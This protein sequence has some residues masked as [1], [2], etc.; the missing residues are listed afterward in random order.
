MSKD[1]HDQLLEKM[2]QYFDLNLHWEGRRT[3]V[4]GIE[5]R[6]LLSDIRRL[7]SQRRVEIQAVRDQKPRLKSP[8]YRE[9]I[10]KA[11]GEQKS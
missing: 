9:S 6:R 1:V 10:S 5:L 7:C 8:K 3:H 2:H 4:A 11:Q